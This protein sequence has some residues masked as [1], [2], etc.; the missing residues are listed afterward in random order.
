MAKIHFTRE[1]V[2]V[3]RFLGEFKI[4]TQAELP[5]PKFILGNGDNNARMPA[6]LWALLINGSKIWIIGSHGSAA[7]EGAAREQGD[8]ALAAAYC[9]V[10]VGA[11]VMDKLGICCWIIQCII[12][13][14]PA[15]NIRHFELKIS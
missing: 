9:A 11:W 4:H 6:P 13:H 14:N 10:L 2:V 12:R 1:M 3:S 7:K 8:K 5:K 15:E